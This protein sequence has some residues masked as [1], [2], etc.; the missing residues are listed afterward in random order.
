MDKTGITLD[1]LER[2]DAP[3]AEHI[4]DLYTQ[5]MVPSESGGGYTQYYKCP[6]AK[7]HVVDEKTGDHEHITYFTCDECMVKYDIVK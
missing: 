6:C 7:G 1:Q 3:M 5:K 4:K 2:V